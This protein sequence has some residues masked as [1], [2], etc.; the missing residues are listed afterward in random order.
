MEEPSIVMVEVYDPR[1]HPPT[2]FHK[3]RTPTVP[4]MDGMPEKRLSKVENRTVGRSEIRKVNSDLSKASTQS[5][6]IETV[7]LPS[8]IKTLDT[9]SLLTRSS[10][11]QPK[12][13]GRGNKKV[14][15]VEKSPSTRHSNNVKVVCMEDL[16]PSKRAGRIAGGLGVTRN[17]AF[18]H[19]TTQ[20][21][22]KSDK[23]RVVRNVG[24]S[25][26][27]KNNHTTVDSMRAVYLGGSHTRTPSPTLSTS[28]PPRTPPLHQNLGRNGKIKPYIEYA[29]LN[30]KEGR[31]ECTGKKAKRIQSLIESND[32]FSY[33]LVYHGLWGERNYY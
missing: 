16:L 33:L 32:P 8:E 24:E 20:N 4:G 21:G 3:K 18:S 27:K 13:D 12:E 7:E 15:K 2:F 29:G 5:S 17:P 1:T 10:E 23:T 6:E 25:I 30:T 14:Q 22:N 11:S 28:P 19:Q 31:K 26:L 9:H